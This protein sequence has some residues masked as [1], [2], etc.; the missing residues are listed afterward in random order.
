M[1]AAS[2]SATERALDAR[3][4]RVNRGRH[5]LG[6][7]VI[8]VLTLALAAWAVW[9]AWGQSSGQVSGLV[10]SYAV[11]SPHAIRVTVQITRPSGQAAHCAV[12]ALA[13][14]HSRVGEDVVRITTA[15]PTT[16]VRTL[17]IRTDREATTA[18]IGTCR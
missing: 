18:D 3:Y 13:S 15:G 12:W 4:G 8:A 17:V 5:R 9:A 6:V 7:A 1:P 2:D 16:A 10:Q 14:D 11:T